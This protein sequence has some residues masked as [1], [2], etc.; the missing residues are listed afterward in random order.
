MLGLVEPQSSGIAGGA[1]LLYYDAHMRKVSAIDGR[2]RAPAGAQPDMFLDE[3]GKPL[4]FVVAVRS[5]RSTGVPGA[6]AMLHAAHARFGALRWKDLFQPAIR[7]AS[8]GF[9]VPARLARPVWGGPVGAPQSATPPAPP[10][11]LDS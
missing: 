11:A 3:H 5:G 6:I 7:A 2:E 8:L 4:P 10:H 9:R 1:F